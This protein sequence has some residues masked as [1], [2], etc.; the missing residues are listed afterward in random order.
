[1]MFVP[2]SYDV[3]HY[4]R[5]KYTKDRNWRNVYDELAAVNREYADKVDMFIAV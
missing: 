4:Q 3:L 1:M 5:M 2:Q